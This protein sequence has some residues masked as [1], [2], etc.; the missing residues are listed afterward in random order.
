M[1]ALYRAGRLYPTHRRVE[2]TPHKVTFKVSGCVVGIK[3]IKEAIAAVAPC[4]SNR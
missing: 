3:S 2:E 4:G 1:S